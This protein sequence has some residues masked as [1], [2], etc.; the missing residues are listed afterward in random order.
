M[1]EITVMLEA[2]AQGQRQAS[3]DLLP[4]VYEELRRLAGVR[5]ARENAGQTLQPTALV[6]EAWLQLVRGGERSW[7]NR[8]HFY[9]AAADAMRRILIDQARRKARLRHGGGQARVDVQ[10]I[11][12]A[13]TTPDDN[14]VLIDE[15]LRQLEKGDPIPVPLTHTA[16]ARLEDGRRSAGS[17]A[18]MDAG[19]DAV[20][21]AVVYGSQQSSS[22][23]NGTIT[24]PE[25]ATLEGDQSQGG[26]IV[27]APNIGRG[28]FG[29]RGAAV[30]GEVN[31]SVG[32]FPDG[33]DTDS[34]C[35]D[36]PVQTDTSLSAD[37][38][39]GANKMN[40]GR[41]SGFG[42]GQTIVIDSGPNREIAV[43]ATVGTPGATTVGAAIERGATVIP[44]ASATGFGVGQTVT[45][46]SDANRETA[47]VASV[48]GD[49]RGGFGGGRGNSGGG[50]AI[51]VAAPL[52]LAH[53][54]GAPLSGSGITVTTALTKPHASGAQVGGGHPTPGAPNHYTRRT[55]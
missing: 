54:A 26:C 46:D 41:V 25:L 13:A 8:A 49:G 40:V 16:P 17:I 3:E 31:R 55:Q 22:S 45:I 28:G 34:N 43:I 10:D 50:N 7:Q 33:A 23:A 35:R 32:R 42:V 51:T 53:E 14:V 21:D 20:V 37:S 29:R 6:H 15:A 36:F 1:S 47:V 2:V 44:V 19:G 30:P 12:L 11:D 38:P 24:S 27:V 48:T 9:G 39:A 52:S 5:M 18:L 4:L